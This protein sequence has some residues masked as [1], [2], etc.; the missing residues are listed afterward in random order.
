MHV[1]KQYATRM[2]ILAYLHIHAVNIAKAETNWYELK[3]E[4]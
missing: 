4:L 2:S 1:F 3:H